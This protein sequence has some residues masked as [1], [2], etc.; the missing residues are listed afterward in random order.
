RHSLPRQLEWSLRSGTQY[1]GEMRVACI[2]YLI[3][4]L[5]CGRVGFSEHVAGDA[6]GDTDAMIG[7]ANVIAHY[8]LETPPAAGVFDDSGHGIDG[9]CMSSSCP[10]VVPGH[11]GSAY[12]FDGGDDR[13]IIADSGR[14]DLVTGFTIALWVNPETVTTGC[15]T[16]IAK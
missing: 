15:A 10:L 5:A 1:D 13:L 3:A 16:A 2:A 8:A 4:L 7:S 9:A 11:L 12:R 6:N 14:L